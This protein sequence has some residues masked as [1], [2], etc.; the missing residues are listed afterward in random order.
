M[1]AVKIAAAELFRYAIPFTQP[2]SLGGETLEV[3]RGLLIRLSDEAGHAAWGEAAPLPGFSRETLREAEAALRQVARRLKG[4]AVADALDTFV[5]KA[6]VGPRGGAVM[7]SVYFAV[8]SACLDLRAQAAGLPLRCLLQPACAPEITLNALLSGNETQILARARVAAQAG[9]T[10]LKL[11]VGQRLL[12]DDLRLIQAVRATAGPAAVI[13]LDANRRWDLESAV[14][15]MRAV[16]EQRIEYIEEPVADPLQLPAFLAQAEVPYAL[17]E[18][19]QYPADLLARAR[20]AGR[21]PIA[22]MQELL[23]RA[24]AWVWKPTLA[25]RPIL[26]AARKVYPRQPVVVSSAFESG[27]GI[28]ALAQYAAAYSGAT[29]ACGLDTYAWLAEDV[30]APRLPL[31]GGMLHADLIAEAGRRVAVDRLE[32]LTD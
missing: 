32:P 13:R 7:P 17:D 8:E 6:M 22:V 14:I 20:A 2:V 28:A 18:T 27:V 25:Q 23:P 5:E 12:Q 30:C 9:Y 16:R 11:K 10:V 21:S 19:L 26:D 4:I 24:L 31:R 3:R 15:V 1:A 29:L